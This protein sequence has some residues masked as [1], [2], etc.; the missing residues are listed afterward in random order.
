MKKVFI[1]LLVFCQLFVA[2]VVNADTFLHTDL[3]FVLK[4]SITLDGE[5]DMDRLEDNELLLHKY[6]GSI[7][8]MTKE[9]LQRLDRNE[10]IIYWMNVYEACLLKLILLNP[11]AE[12]LIEF[13]RGP[14]DKFFNV[15]ESKLSFNEII[16]IY[17]RGFIADERVLLSLSNL[18]ADSPIMK[19][20][21][22][23][24]T[25]INIELESR[26]NE[27]LSK[28]SN[29]KIDEENKKIYLSR[30]FLWNGIDFVRRYATQVRSLQ[31]FKLRDRA[32]LNF[33]SAYR[34]NDSEFIL[35]G[36]YEIEY[37]KFDWTIRKVKK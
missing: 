18:T 6:L 35:A 34:P 15:L 36:N 14:N 11:L 12:K 20:C 30:I 13:S 22:F 17:V 1:V 8:A 25:D 16:Q 26:V 37:M 3:E 7:A 21:V 19:N 24:S 23:V 28:E 33:I 29:F 9:D 32:V 31:K 5:L 2:S 27:F 4:N 10:K